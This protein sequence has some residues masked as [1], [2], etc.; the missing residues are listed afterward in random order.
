MRS[1]HFPVSFSGQLGQDFSCIV[2]LQILVGRTYYFKR[3]QTPP[4]AVSFSPLNKRETLRSVVF[5]GHINVPIR[6]SLIFPKIYS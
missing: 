5:L 4:A 6:A 2:L 3:A 1:L